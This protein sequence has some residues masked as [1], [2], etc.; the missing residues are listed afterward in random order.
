MPGRTM[1]LFLLLVG[2]LSAQSNRQFAGPGLAWR[3]RVHLI[4]VGG[5]SCDSSTH[6]EFVGANSMPVARGFA[7]RQCLVEFFR[8]PVGAYHVTVDGP[9][10]QDASTDVEVAASDQT[11]I[12]DLEVRVRPAGFNQVAGSPS[13][14]F[15]SAV[16]LGI[17][18]S[19]AKE[20]SKA[21]RL[22][23]KQDWGKAIEKLQKAVAIDPSFA[24]AYNNL[25]VAY[26][27]AGDATRGREALQKAIG[28]NDHLAAAYVNLSRISIAANNFAEAETL[29]GKAAGIAPADAT[30]MVLLAYVEAR[31]EH[32]DQ[33]IATSR[34]AHAAVEGQHAFV[35][36]AAAHAFEQKR[37][38][39]DA[40][41]ELQVYLNEDP[42]TP[43]AD[44]V[45]RAIATL[46]ASQQV[47]GA[48]A[49][50][51]SVHPVTE[52]ER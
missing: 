45:R 1:V 26:S 46:Q 13:N 18:E 9:N 36:L 38:I 8:V 29:L 15:I 21:S 32:L 42:A 51:Q 40:I 22:I 27:R 33:T 31:Q 50:A 3:V 44:E 48:K 47:A 14:A 39:G 17:P 7:S 25:G 28:I 11:D 49:R 30:T 34:Q 16:D 35:H 12:Q 19:A 4:L 43:Q 2:C 52:P 5:A 23:E 10:V 20:F 37:M 6:V 24:A 41:S